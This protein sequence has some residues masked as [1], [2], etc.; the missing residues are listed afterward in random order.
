MPFI[1]IA[2]PPGDL[3]RASREIDHMLAG[4]AAGLHD[5]TRFPG[6]EA[7][8]CRPDRLMVAVE[9]RRVETS[10]GFDRPA[11]LAEF[12]DIFRHGALRTHSL[13]KS[14]CI[15]WRRRE[16]RRLPP[17]G[18]APGPPVFITYDSAFSRH[19]VPESCICRS[20]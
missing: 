8:Q 10:V 1:Q 13:A 18:A 5:V 9:R 3:G 17:R 14:T 12:L 15:Q 6:K 2:R 7:F 20:E 4:A 16:P 11:V 19:T